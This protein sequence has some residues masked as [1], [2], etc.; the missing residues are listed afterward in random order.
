M[1]ETSYLVME[2]HANSTPVQV[3][4][5]CMCLP[6]NKAKENGHCQKK[7]CQGFGRRFGK[8]RMF[9][10]PFFKTN[11]QELST[12]CIYPKQLLN[13]TKKVS[14]NK[15]LSNISQLFPNMFDPAAL[16]E[17]PIN[18]NDLHRVLFGNHAI[19]RNASTLRQDLRW[20]D[21]EG[22]LLEQ[23]L[24]PIQAIKESTLKLWQVC[25]P[26]QSCRS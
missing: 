24:K 14:I 16:K 7:Y 18:N 12:L 22:H 13:K 17:H 15:T 8:G 21:I 20:D 3:Y 11:P 5:T 10:R 1:L 23:L 4:A 6:K 2:T 25:R 26:V 19:E 9:G